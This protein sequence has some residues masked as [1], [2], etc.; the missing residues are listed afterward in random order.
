[1]GLGPIPGTKNGMIFGALSL[2]W[3]AL[4][5]LDAGGRGLVLSQLSAPDFVDFPREH[6]LIGSS[7]W[8]VG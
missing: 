3:G 2:R 7:G 6:L 1:M 8:G 5:R 4:F